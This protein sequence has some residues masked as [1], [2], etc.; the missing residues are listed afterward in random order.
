[1][2]SENIYDVLDDFIKS[3]KH[4]EN[5]GTRS[6]DNIEM[7]LKDS[8]SI[9]KGIKPEYIIVK[10][11]YICSK[12]AILFKDLKSLTKHIKGHG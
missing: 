11:G 3:R 4:R 10:D 12:C 5:I 2:S 8:S 1:M 9:S 6:T 7:I